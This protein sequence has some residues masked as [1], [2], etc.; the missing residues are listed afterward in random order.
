[1]QES[2]A[3]VQANVDAINRFA[4][5]IISSVNAETQ[6]ERLA[7]YDAINNAGELQAHI[8]ECLFITDVIM[9]PIELESADGDGKKQAYRIVLI[10]ENG[11][12][13]GTVSS[14]VETS[15]RNLFAVVGNPP[16][17][18][19]IPLT[20]VSKKGRSGWNFTTLDYTPQR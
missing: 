17:H 1:M 2:N 3:M 20:P 10:D 19:A 14:G 13:Y 16:W 6:E 8:G 15:M 18:P 4:G 5:G 7:I 11:Q 12:T 9:Q